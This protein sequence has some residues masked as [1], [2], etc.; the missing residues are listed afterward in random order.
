VIGLAL[1][2]A[3]DAAEARSAQ[4][5]K[6]A[7]AA[8]PRMGTVLRITAY[9]PE[10][11]KAID[12]AFAEVE[13]L[14]ALLSNYRTDSELSRLNAGAGQGPRKIGPDL[15]EFLS[16]CRR[17]TDATE[18]AF[19]PTLGPVVRAWGFTDRK[20]RVPSDEELARLRERIGP[21][22]W[23]VTKDAAELK[24]AGMELDPGAIGKGY[25]VDRAA[26]VLKARGVTV[27]LIDFGSTQV[28]MGA[29]PGKEGWIIGIRDP[30]APDRFVSKQVVKDG[31]VS[32]SGSAEK[33][34][35][36][37]GKRYGH[38]L[39][40]RT[41][42]PVEGVVSVSIRGADGTSTDAAATAIFVLGPEAGRALAEKVGVEAL[43]FGADGKK[44]VTRGW[45]E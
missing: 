13:R 2:L 35:E 12:A 37:E 41:L 20:Y 28:A 1:A 42:R 22:R 32:T 38:I 4:Q 8:R 19:D 39:D 43:I 31:A 40:P 30:S 34:F 9:G 24:A 6:P 25:A 11:G 3:L 23:I 10:A 33:F 36:V 18:G 7:T 14:E 45:K 26:Q 16:V 15:A 17:W 21:E 29:P 5:E 27:A 44:T